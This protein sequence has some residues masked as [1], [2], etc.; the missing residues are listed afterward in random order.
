MALTIQLY[1][2]IIICYNL[3]H[4]F[5]SPITHLLHCSHCTKSWQTHSSTFSPALGKINIS[6]CSPTLTNHRNLT[7]TTHTLLHTHTHT[8]TLPHKLWQSQHTQMYP[9]MHKLT[10]NQIP[11]ANMLI[12]DH[13]IVHPGVTIQYPR[14]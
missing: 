6:L 8:H 3:F 4:L 7:N 2:L 1:Y 14:D 11:H 13:N 9:Q 5:L 10:S 12:I